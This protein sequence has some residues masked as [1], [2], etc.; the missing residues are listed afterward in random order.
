M[1]RARAL[2]SLFVIESSGLAFHGCPFRTI[3]PRRVSQPR[4]G[5]STESP[6]IVAI[7][8]RGISAAADGLKLAADGEGTVRRPDDPPADPPAAPRVSRQGRDPRN[9]PCLV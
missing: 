7:P 1:L 2:S 4:F 9:E 8:V 5:L 6:R 3:R